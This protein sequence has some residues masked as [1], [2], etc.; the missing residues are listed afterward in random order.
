[1]RQK[2]FD[3]LVKVIVH[4][5]GTVLL[6]CLLLTILMLPGMGRIRMKTDIVDMLPKGYPQVES[7]TRIYDDFGA[8]GTET[9]TIESKTADTDLMKKCAEDVA[10]RLEM[11]HFLKPK[12]DQELTREQKKALGKKEHPVAGV[13]YDTTFIAKRVEYKLDPE[14]INKHGFI[15]QKKSDLET[16]LE[17][18][19][20][21]DLAGLLENMNDNFEKEYVENEANLSSFEGEQRALYG[22]GAIEDFLDGMDGFLDDRDPAHAGRSAKGLVSGP[23]YMLSPD[24]TLLILRLICFDTIAENAEDANKLGSLL[25]EMIKEVQADYPDL[26]IGGTGDSIFSYDI[27]KSSREDMGISSIISLVLILILLIGSFST[28]KNPFF[29]LVTLITALIWTTGFIGYTLHY[30]NIMSIIFGIVLIGLGIDFGI[31]YIS[32]FR[33]GRNKELSLE[34]SVRFM[35]EKFGNGVITGALTT[36]IAF[37][38]LSFSGFRALVEM[39]IACGAGI[40]FCMVAMTVL[41]P[42]LFVWSSKRRYLFKMPSVQSTGKVFSFSFLERVGTFT[43]NTKV[44]I[45]VI[46]LTVLS[47]YWSIAH[48]KDIGY[49]YNMMELESE[50]IMTAVNQRKILDKFEISPDFVMLTADNLDDCREKSR[51]IKKIADKTGLIGRID[52]VSEFLPSEE[53]Q[54]E[55]IPLIE[56]FRKE[57]ASRKITNHIS[58]D[59]KTKI[60]VELDRLHKNIVEIGEMSIS[61]HGEENKLLTR[62]DM[63]TGRD[64]RQSKI[65]QLAEKIK[66]KENV[67]QTLGNFQ[68]GAFEDIRKH[69]LVRAN[70]ETVSLDN[71]PENIRGRYVCEK[72]SSLLMNVY[73]K[74]L[75]WNRTYL[76]RFITQMKKVSEGTTAG[77]IIGFLFFD[78]MID[79]GRIATMYAMCAII[80]LLLVDFRSFKYMIFAI[81]PVIVGAC[82]MVGGMYLTGIKFN[83]ANFMV[84][85]LILG[86]GIDD[87]V[88]VLHRYRTE[89]TGSIPKVLRFTGRAVLLTSLTTMIAFGAMSFGVRKGNASAAQV[90]VMGVGACL[91]SSTIVLPAVIS[92]YE[93]IFKEKK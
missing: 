64:D 52:A 69:L 78:I 84:L 67:E 56:S 62:C 54:A 58:T 71:L 17:M 47:L 21:M 30:L 18:Y 9:V 60:C 36:S 31:H 14:F 61:S 29:A 87:G 2:L 70:S 16:A 51:Q 26:I 35:Y 57:L 40:V 10:A 55:N 66:R 5:P 79:K 19:S 15:I 39:G 7:L 59:D 28:W 4:R 73:P 92:L 80:I 11:L 27:L 23:E 13:L 86:I 93:R 76:Q 89:G 25:V 48:V 8:G 50:N 75:I 53:E 68:K 72:N 43:Q 83:I 34:E 45:L 77:P 37:F 1:M 82:W 20:S 41:L 12:P 90:L 3:L 6:L 24:K 33:D 63:L 91:I 32:G 85:P 74:G 22:L 65:L 44:S 81:I 38:S 46:V 88:H 42:A 49:E